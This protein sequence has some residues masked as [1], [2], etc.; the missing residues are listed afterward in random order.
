MASD[1]HESY[2]ERMAE[3]EEGEESH[4]GITCEFCDIEATHER[5]AVD[6]NAPGNNLNEPGYRKQYLCWLHARR[7]S[8][9][10]ARV[11]L[12]WKD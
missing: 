3:S 2:Y 7:A 4:S 12:I 5:Y 11:T 8:E 10:G 1:L 9:E 6:T